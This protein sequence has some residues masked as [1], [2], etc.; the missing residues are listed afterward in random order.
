MSTF[1]YN[2]LGTTA[3]KLQVRCGPL[4]NHFLYLRAEKKTT[5]TKENRLD[6]K[7]R[8]M[9]KYTNIHITILHHFIIYI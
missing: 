5:F 8:T 2:H 9:E 6:C 7:M 4:Y 3:P 1:L